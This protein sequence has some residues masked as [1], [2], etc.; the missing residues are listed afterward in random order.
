MLNMLRMILG[1]V[2]MLSATT[3]LGLQIVFGVIG[4]GFFFY[5]L[6]VN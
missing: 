4:L 2:L 6:A 5:S 3:G 1:L